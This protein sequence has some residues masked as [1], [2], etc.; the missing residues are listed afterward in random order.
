MVS[1]NLDQHMVCKFKLLRQGHFVQNVGK[2]MILVNARRRCC[3][4]T[5]V[6]NQDTFLGNALKTRMLPQQL[7]N[8]RQGLKQGDEFSLLVQL[9][10]LDPQT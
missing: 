4:V 5:H 2:H 9:R 3:F 8:Q 1:P 7:G 10:Q 6:G